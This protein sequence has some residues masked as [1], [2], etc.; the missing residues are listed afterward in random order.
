MTNYVDPKQEIRVAVDAV[1]ICEIKLKKYVLFIKRQYQPFEGLFA[2]PGGF[3]L[4]NEEL[5]HG[6]IRE[7]KEETNLDSKVHSIN[8]I[9]T[10]GKIGRDPRRR[11]ISVAFIVNLGILKKLPIVSAANE[12]LDVC[13]IVLE[14]INK[15]KFAFDH[16][17]ILDAAIKSID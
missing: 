11:I 16:K 8:Q 13:W 5:E 4:S 12:S 3:L 17:E 2:L 9:G 14:D 7:L 6:V 10:F 15:H 1:C